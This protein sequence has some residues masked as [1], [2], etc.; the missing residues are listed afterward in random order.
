MTRNEKDR[1]VTDEISN[2]QNDLSDFRQFVIESFIR[3][4]VAVT[5]D[6]IKHLI[7]GDCKENFTRPRLIPRREAASLLLL[8]LLCVPSKTNNSRQ[9]NYDPSCSFLKAET[10]SDV[11][12]RNVANCVYSH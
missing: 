12:D 8:T 11:Q 3:L 7:I 5:T 6:S 1:D 4:L 2:Y 9:I 10:A